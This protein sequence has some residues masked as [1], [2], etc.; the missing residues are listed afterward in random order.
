MTLAASTNSPFLIIGAQRSGTSLLS[1]ILNQ[2]PGIAVPPESFFFNT[3]GPL[4][5]FYGDL[6]LAENRDRLIDDALSTVKMRE[7]SPRPSRTAVQAHIREQT[8]GGVFRAILDAW[9]ETQHKGRW[10]EKTPHNALC[11]TDVHE[12]LPEVPLLHIVR[13]GRDVAL[14]LM[15]SKFGPKTVYAAA[16]RW[17]RYLRAIADI[18][19]SIGPGQLHEIRYEELLQRP[20]EVLTGVCAFLG[21]SYSP[22]M[23]EFYKDSTAYSEYDAEHRNLRNPLMPEKVARWRRKMAPAEVRVFESVAARELAAYGYTL[24]TQAAPLRG[25]ERFYLGWIVNPPK[26]VFALLRNDVGRAEELHLLKVRSWII[27][28][29]GLRLLTGKR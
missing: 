20:E 5:R 29:Q 17:R 8:L 22:Q 3:F 1:R 19:S 15:A 18:K 28:R 21:E 11:W 7:W 2:H 10:G 16:H 4:R 27:S 13:D 24:A 14:S 9:T 23:L 26:K 6:S 12:A 25:L